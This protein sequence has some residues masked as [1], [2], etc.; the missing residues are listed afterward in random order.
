MQIGT[1]AG[2]TGLTTKTIRFYE[3]RGLLPAP[4][5]TR[6]GYRDYPAESVQRLRF[7]RDAQTA[8]LAL[9]E[10]AGILTVRDGGQAPCTQVAV[11]L[12]AHLDRVEQ[13][14]ADL[15]AARAVL[16]DLATRAAEIQPE[17]CLEV[18]I[19]TILRSPAHGDRGAGEATRSV[20]ME[21]A[22]DPRELREARRAGISQDL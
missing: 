16:R 17:T 13:R 7:I 20:A 9:T 19:C 8:G 15:Q 21:N 18:D 5:R 10:I 11:L 6:G 12:A 14:L 1:L 4:P 3:R 2:A 22:E